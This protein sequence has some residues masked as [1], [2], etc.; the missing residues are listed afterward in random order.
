MHRVHDLKFKMLPKTAVVF[1][2][3]KKFERFVFYDRNSIELNF[4]GEE[5]DRIYALDKFNNSTV[6]AN[7]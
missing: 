1:G 5:H 4:H 3:L 2:D 6:P 7:T